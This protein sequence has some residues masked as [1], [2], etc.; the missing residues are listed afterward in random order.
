[1]GNKGK[2]E[3]KNE[4]IRD[5]SSAF[6]QG[7]EGTGPLDG[8]KFDVILYRRGLEDWEIVVEESYIGDG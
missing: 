2:I 3:L 4:R 5:H 8:G 1:M 6:E 7:E